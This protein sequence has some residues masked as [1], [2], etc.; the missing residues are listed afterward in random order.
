MRDLTPFLGDI[1]TMPNPFGKDSQAFTNR[2]KELEDKLQ[3]AKDA[4]Q[5]DRSKQGP[6]FVVGEVLEIRGGRFQITRIEPGH[7]R[8]KGL[9]AE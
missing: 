1:P 5:P 8:L 4:I 2:L 9:P 6:V 3:Q 7:I